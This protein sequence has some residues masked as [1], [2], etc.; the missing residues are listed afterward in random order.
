MTR[1]EGKQ[2]S[3]QRQANVA[4]IVASVLAQVGCLTLLLVGVAIGLG[5][6]LDAQLGTGGLST[7]ILVLASVPLTFYF[8]IRLVLRGTSDLQRKANLKTNQIEIEEEQGGEN[9]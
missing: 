6:W 5:R 2:D 9:P 1:T 3:D 7:V 8:V 4:F